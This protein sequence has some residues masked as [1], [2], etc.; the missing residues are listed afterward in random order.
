MNSLEQNENWNHQKNRLKQKFVFLK[1][2][3]LDIKN[4]KADEM[5]DRLQIKLRISKEELTD[6]ITKL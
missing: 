5:L 3:D 2:T 4:G 1:D 6:I